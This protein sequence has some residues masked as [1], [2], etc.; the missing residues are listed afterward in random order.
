MQGFYWHRSSVLT[1]CY[2]TTVNLM[3]Q[4]IRP[5]PCGNFFFTLKNRENICGSAAAA[6][7]PHWS[8]SRN[9]L[10]T[11]VFHW[12]A[13]AEEK[14]HIQDA[15]VRVRPTNGAWRAPSPQ[16]HNGGS[17]VLKAAKRWQKDGWSWI[18]S[19]AKEAAKD[20]KLGQALSS[21]RTTTLGVMPEIW[22][23]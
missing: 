1:F 7:E 15:C 9:Y 20:W 16:T 5:C 10:C 17:M 4:S 21:N 19:E 13:K 6:A 23:E 11:V 8:T 2:I 14:E 3:F 12:Q 18:Q 22:M